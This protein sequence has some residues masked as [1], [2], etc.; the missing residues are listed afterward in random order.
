M[1]SSQGQNSI[2]DESAMSIEKG[3]E[4][5]ILFNVPFVTDNGHLSF[6]DKISKLAL[7]GCPNTRRRMGDKKC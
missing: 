4:S 1:H 3:Y 7:L 5:A 6:Y 2:K